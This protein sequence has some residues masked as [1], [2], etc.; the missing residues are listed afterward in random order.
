MSETETGGLQSLRVNVHARFQLTTLST[1]WAGK[2]NIK[3]FTK[4]LDVFVKIQPRVVS[5]VSCI[6]KSANETQFIRI[7]C[8][9]KVPS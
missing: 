1:R 8:K 5:L 6:N 3:D 7:R 4:F 2:K 9:S